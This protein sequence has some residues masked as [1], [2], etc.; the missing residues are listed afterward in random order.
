VYERRGAVLVLCSERSSEVN[1]G[2]LQVRSPRFKAYISGEIISVICRIAAS[3]P[4]SPSPVRIVDAV[5][6]YLT[7]LL[8]KIRT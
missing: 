2:G 8:P 3:R 6:P 4:R 1:V 7:D 5:T